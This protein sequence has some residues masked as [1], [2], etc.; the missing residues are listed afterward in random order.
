MLNTLTLTHIPASWRGHIALLVAVAS[1]SLAAI[2][3]RFAQHDGVPSPVIASFRLTVGALILTPFVLQRYKH[4]L[5]QLSR[6]EFVFSILA[7]FWLAVHLTA[8][9]LSLEHT[10]VLISSVLLGTGPL[11]IALLEVY[12]LKIHLR[13]RVW[14]GLSFALSGGVVIA[15]SGS[16]GE[17]TFGH[18]PLLGAA[19]AIVAAVLSAVY[20]ITGRKIRA[21]VAVLP[22]IWLVFTSAAITSLF[23]VLVSRAQVLGFSPDAY[24]W[25]V[26]LT[27]IPQLMGH[28]AWNYALGH[29]SA[30]YI[31]VIGQLGIVLSAVI[32]YFILREQPGV[33]Q[34][35][36]SV[37]I[38]IGVTLVNLGQS[39]TE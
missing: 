12:L 24:L 23:I 28:G 19:L 37:A 11:W 25:L 33:L 21:R 2:L 39:R 15:L 38:V 8:V 13:S 35:P 27:I 16:G 30:T 32:A 5:R 34:L 3:V 29:L 10:S 31:S 4:D 36:G 20:S 17:I 9:T 18:N 26:V 7:G 6:R 22:Y 14:I 1:G